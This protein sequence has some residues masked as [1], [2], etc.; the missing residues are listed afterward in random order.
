[1]S[2]TVTVR[3]AS[4]QLGLHLIACPVCVGDLLQL[5]REPDLGTLH[6]TDM[7]TVVATSVPKGMVVPFELSTPRDVSPGRWSLSYMYQRVPIHLWD[8]ISHRLNCGERYI[9]ATCRVAMSIILGLFDDFD[10][11]PVSLGSMLDKCHY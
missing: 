11:L 9:S 7:G 1:M 4:H 8:Y 2:I 5:G 6:T 10:L 3:S